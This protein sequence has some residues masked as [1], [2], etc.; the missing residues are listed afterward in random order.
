MSLFLGQ[1]PYVTLA[2]EPELLS[3]EAWLRLMAE[4]G[5]H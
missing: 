5:R 4:F 1:V 2:F 3:A